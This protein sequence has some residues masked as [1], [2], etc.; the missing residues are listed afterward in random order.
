MAIMAAESASPSSSAR[1]KASE[2]IPIGTE[3][4]KTRSS[5]ALNWT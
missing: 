1:E 3:K 5:S 4:K 2:A